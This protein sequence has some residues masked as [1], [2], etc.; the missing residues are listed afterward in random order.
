MKNILLLNAKRRIYLYK[1]MKKYL[2][3]RDLK[4]KIIASDINQFDPISKVA[5]EFIILPKITDSSFKDVL[6]KEIKEKEIGGILIWNDKDFLYMNQIKEELEKLNVTIISPEPLKL[7]ICNNKLKT[8]EF[9][10][11]NN[12][13][14]PTLYK[15]IE[16]IKKF[17]VILKPYDGAGSMDIYIANN[18]EEARSDF[19]KIKSKNPIIEEYIEGEHYTVDIFSDY[20][21][22]PFCIVPRKRIKVHG[23]EVLI[24]K[25]ELEEKIIEFSKKIAIVLKIIGPINIQFIVDKNKKIYL[26]EINPR[27]GGGTDLTIEAGAN[28]EKWI[29]QILIN[30]KL[31]KKFVLENGL[32]MSR[33][34]DEVFFHDTIK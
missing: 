19:N 12:F 13:L 14:M 32:Y 7:E 24:A 10:S 1:K 8:H 23:S 2:E 3:E 11:E 28:F 16:E 26:I 22:T 33:Y 27:I 25:I 29:V 34:Y 6:I 9:A 17:P 31:D 20:N 30:E 15:K 5:E 18:I 4:I 21:G